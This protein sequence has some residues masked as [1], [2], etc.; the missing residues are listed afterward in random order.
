MATEPLKVSVLADGELLLDG[1]PVT[2]AELERAMDRAAKASAA[3]WYYRENPAGDPSPVALEVMKLITR[4]HLPVRLSS[5]P[6]FSDSVTSSSTR[7]LDQMFASMREKAAQR[8][9]VILRPDGRHMLLPAQKRSASPPQAVAAVEKILPSI[10]QR[11]VAVIGDTAWTLAD[12]PSLKAANQAIPFFGLL[13]GFSTI[14]HAVWIFDATAAAT[15]AAGCRDADLAIVDS[16]R[17]PALPQGWQDHVKKVMR[18]PRVLVHDRAT[19]QL[20]KA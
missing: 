10:V 14:G 17:L 9:I 18:T 1:Q 12:A 15:L 2:L 5:K 11:N 4:N 19:Y 8:K 6:D 13:M 3:V 20:R 7:G 16:A